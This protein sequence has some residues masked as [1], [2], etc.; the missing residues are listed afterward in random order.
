V[1]LSTSNK[2]WKVKW[3]YMENIHV[4]DEEV[5]LT[6]NIDIEAKANLNWSAKPSGDEM[7]YVEELLNI[8]A[9]VKINGIECT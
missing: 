3:F 9:R 4:K 7:V 5:E 6:E 8:L 1:P 2:G